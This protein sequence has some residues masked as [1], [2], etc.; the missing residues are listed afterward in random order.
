MET[1]GGKVSISPDKGKGAF[2]NNE[3]IVYL[4]DFHNF[5]LLHTF[6]PDNSS[7]RA[8]CTVTFDSSSSY[9]IIESD[10]ANPLQVVDITNYSIIFN[11]S[12]PGIIFAASFI[13]VSTNFIVVIGD[14]GNCL[15]DTR[16]GLKYS[17]S[18]MVISSIFAVD[19][20]NN[21][22]YLC[23]DNTIYEYNF[24]FAALSPTNSTELPAT[25]EESTFY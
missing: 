15:I 7:L 14:S 4:Y 12:Y 18:E 19:Y 24:Q 10:N 11:A 23:K 22:F 8:T 13:G 3:S 5:S 6:Y 2:Y 9:M 17:I 25:I 21:N 16:T 20:A 1:V